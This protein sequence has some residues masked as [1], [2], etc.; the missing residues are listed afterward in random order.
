MATL[1]N[2]VRP[3]DLPPGMRR[4]SVLVLLLVL[5]LGCTDSDERARGVSP[6]A[7]IRLLPLPNAG[8]PT[9]PDAGPLA[10]AAR[11]RDGAPNTSPPVAGAMATQPADPNAFAEDPPRTSPSDGLRADAPAL[12]MRRG[13]DAVRRLFCGPKAPV[14]AGLADLI[15]SL[16]LTV[17]TL[18][19]HSTALGGQ[20]VSEINP[21]SIH[22]RSGACGDFSALAFVRGEQRVELASYDHIPG[23]FNFYLLEFRQ[24]CNDASGGCSHGDLFTPAIEQGW[25]ALR[26]TDDEELKNSAQDCRRC[27]QRGAREPLHEPVLLMRELFSPWT[28][29]F[30]SDQPS[31]EL[32]ERYRSAKGDEPYAGFDPDEIVGISAGGPLQLQRV[33]EESQGCEPTH[34]QPLEFSSSTIESELR[35]EGRSRTWRRAYEA[36]RLGEAVAPPYFKPVATDPEKVAA[37]AADYQRFL[38]GELS[39]DE[40]PDMRDVFPDDPQT[41]AEIGLTVEP[42]ASGPALSVQACEACHNGLLDPTLSRARFDVDLTRMSREQLDR[43]IERLSLPEDDPLTMPPKEARTLDPPGRARLIAYLRDFAAPAADD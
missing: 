36:F 6:T 41:R 39:K 3:V 22:L 40:L 14:I 35:M 34:Y 32:R 18:L 28:H 26:L 17:S 15:R 8:L 2:V 7:P 37:R 27:H 5:G 12:C 42:D 43:A 19:G 24:A 23:R 33:I 29:F 11:P 31:S 1:N 30:E 13:D 21:R 4:R 9:R 16:K 10:D 20:L 38:Q 25:Q